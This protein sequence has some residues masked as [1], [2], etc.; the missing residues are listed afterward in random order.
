M[1]DAGRAL[2]AAARPT[3]RGVRQ[4]KR[5]GQGVQRVGG[6]A[7]WD[8]VRGRP[9]ACPCPTTADRHSRRVRTSATGFGGWSAR[10]AM[11]I[12]IQGGLGP[13]TTS[14]PALPSRVAMP[15]GI[16]GGLGHRHRRAMPCIPA[17]AM[18]IG[19]QGGLGRLWGDV[20]RR[21]LPCRN[22]DR[23]SRRVGTTRRRRSPHVLGSR[24]ADR[25]SR[26]VG[27]FGAWW[28]ALALASRNADRHSRRVGTSKVAEE[29][30]VA[31]KSQCRSAF[32]A[33]WD[34]QP[35]RRQVR[36]RVVAMP[37]GIQGGLGP[38]GY[39]TS[40]TWGTE[41]Q[42]RSAFKAGWDHLEHGVGCEEGHVA[43]PIG[44]QGG[45]GRG[46]T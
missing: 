23:H 27:T 16:Q 25:H 5:A 19:I 38:G 13:A 2:P 8:W 42:C 32:K 44:I 20:L 31:A 35:Q 45:L 9:R 10:V 22:A 28:S 6:Q 46:K 36:P 11:P 40:K 43:M 3:N 14:A 18:P 33:G 29:A 7:R 41:S 12:G 37:I 26:R 4:G 30:L 39:W 1:L 15:I 21:S 24:N 17:V 34:Q